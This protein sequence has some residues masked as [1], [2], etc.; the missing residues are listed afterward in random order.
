MGGT[1]QETDYKALYEE[2]LDEYQKLEEYCEFI[3]RENI[4]LAWNLAGYEGAY[5]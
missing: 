1:N 5:D 3:E 4:D 2:L